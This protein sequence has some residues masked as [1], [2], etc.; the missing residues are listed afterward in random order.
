MG[1]GIGKG[2]AFTFT[3]SHSFY[4]ADGM[5]PHLAKAESSGLNRD[6]IGLL[7]YQSLE[8]GTMFHCTMIEVP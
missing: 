6:E 1:A 3:L 8:N 7:A 5:L 4:P 2:P